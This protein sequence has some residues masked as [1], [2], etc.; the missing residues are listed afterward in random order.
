MADYEQNGA[1]RWGYLTSI[2]IRNTTLWIGVTL[3]FLAFLPAVYF[4]ERQSMFEIVDGLVTGAAIGVMVG[5]FKAAWHAVKLP[6]HKLVSA[7][8]LVVGVIMIAFFGAVR[9][10]G[11][12]YWRA[13]SKPNWWIDSPML[14]MTTVGIMI[15]LFLILM[16][17]S[18]EKGILLPK[19][20]LKASWLF[21]LSLGIGAVMIWAGWG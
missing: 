7:D 14:L 13:M 21:A 10:A 4:V 3:A 18:S 12:W 2:S 5:Y 6:S 17:T 16:T 9:F 19:A 11:Q 1:S 8:Y 20:Y 15:G